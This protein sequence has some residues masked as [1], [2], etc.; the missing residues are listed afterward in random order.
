M[1]CFSYKDKKCHLQAEEYH[2]KRCKHNVGGFCEAKPEHLTL[3][4]PDCGY[5]HIAGKCDVTQEDTLLVPKGK[6]V[7]EKQVYPKSKT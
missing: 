3:T 1:R 7:K 4:C 6:L 5:A 2:F